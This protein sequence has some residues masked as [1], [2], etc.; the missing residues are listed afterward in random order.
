MSFALFIDMNSVKQ[1]T[2]EDAKRIA[3][4]AEA[5]FRD[6][7]TGTT[8][9]A[10]MELHCR[11]SYGEA[12]QAREILCDTM[13]T[14]FCEDGDSV[15]GFAQMRWGK[16]PTCIANRSAGEILRLYV[17]R[18]WH[19]RGIA[20]ALMSRC[21]EEMRERSMDVVWLGVWEENH[22]ARA[23]YAK[24]GFQKKGSHIYP[25]GEDPQVDLIVS[26]EL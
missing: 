21:L 25:V 8:S 7:F 18:E 19:G 12:I 14:L 11:N 9:D 23:F 22:R 16:P 2:V 17:A 20:H 10:N 13:K 24:Y 3:E 5:S 26:L 4:L 1:A 15:I 6:T